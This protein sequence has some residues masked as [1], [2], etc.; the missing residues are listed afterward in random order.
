MRFVLFAPTL[1]FLHLSSEEE[2]EK[3]LEA[4]LQDFEVVA[5]GDKRDAQWESQIEEMLDAEDLK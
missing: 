2:W 5:D 1:S 3:E 4:E